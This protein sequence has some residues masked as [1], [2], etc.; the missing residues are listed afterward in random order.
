MFT[1]MASK[2][3]PVQA[4]STQIPQAW[5]TPPAATAARPEKATPWAQL[6]EEGGLAAAAAPVEAMVARR[7]S[8]KARPIPA[9][10]LT[11]QEG[12]KKPGKAQKL[13]NL[14]QQYGA[15]YK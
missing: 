6:E 5:G 14:T 3:F 11:V 9:G 1:R 7:K 10:S 4:P 12:F 15:I 2:T 13:N 8:R